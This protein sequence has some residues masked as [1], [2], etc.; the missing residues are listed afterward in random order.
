M[1]TFKLESLSTIHLSPA[2]K[3]DLILNSGTSSPQE[4]AEHIVCYLDM[5]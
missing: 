4:L 3:Y 5:Q 2:H 1:A